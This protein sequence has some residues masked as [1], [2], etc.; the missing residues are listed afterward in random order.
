M[1]G[2]TSGGGTGGGSVVVVTISTACA[3]ELLTALTI[4]L[5]SKPIKKITI[6]ACT[7]T[8]RP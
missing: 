7:M 2:K 1:G 4:A 3:K 5:G 6:E 8:L